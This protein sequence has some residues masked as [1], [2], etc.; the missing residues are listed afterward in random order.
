VLDKSLPSPLAPE[1]DEEK[2]EAKDKEKD[3]AAADEDKPKPPDGDKPAPPA[4]KPAAKP[5]AV[6]VKVDLEDLG[7][8]VI[9]LPLPARNYG[10]L[11]AGKAGT[12]F[13]LELPA[14]LPLGGPQG[15]PGALGAT[16]TKFDLNT[17]KSDPVLSGVSSFELTARGDKALYRQGDKWY[18]R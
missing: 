5:G 10:G 15:G 14:V 8:R 3:G 6:K 4:G 1:S 16:V 11:E 18:I 9:G 2:A 17:R 7:Q 13:L 12:F